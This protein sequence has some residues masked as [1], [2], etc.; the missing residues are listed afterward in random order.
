MQKSSLP[1]IPK[2]VN[3][4]M[5]FL[6]VDTCQIYVY[7]KLGYEVGGV[8]LHTCIDSIMLFIAGVL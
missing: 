1:P 4:N 6:K 8:D 2:P 3:F 7:A 5:Y